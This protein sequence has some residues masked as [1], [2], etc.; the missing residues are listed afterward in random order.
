MDWTNW[1][2]MCVPHVDGEYLP[3]VIGLYLLDMWSV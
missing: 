3:V 1:A 2:V